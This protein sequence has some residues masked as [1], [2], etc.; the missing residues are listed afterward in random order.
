[1][2][3]LA[4]I[5]KMRLYYHHAIILNTNTF[6]FILERILENYILIY[7]YFCKKRF[8]AAA[9]RFVGGICSSIDSLLSMRWTRSNEW[10]HHP[11][12]F[13]RQRQSSLIASS[14]DSVSFHSSLLGS[15][16][17]NRQTPRHRHDLRSRIRTVWMVG[18]RKFYF[19]PTPAMHTVSI[20][21]LPHDES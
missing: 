7:R 2:I 16:E 19:T 1:M 12:Q 18:S 20:L 15:K 3:S 10:R 5:S 13:R 17:Q 8:G 14:T 21:D 4:Q 9:N 11:A 6:I